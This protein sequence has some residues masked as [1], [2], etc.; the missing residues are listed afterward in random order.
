MKT[1]AYALVI[2]AALHGVAVVLAGFAASSLTLIVPAILYL[3]LAAGLSRH[4]M[5]VAWLS[6]IVMLGGIA[7]ALA[8]VVGASPVPTWVFGSILAA[9][10]VAAVLL[11]GAI[12][13][14]R[15]TD[16]R[17]I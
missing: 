7:A 16:Q 13:S 15:R 10:A 9:N 12:W 17:A 14:G 5:W 8:S 4:M 1:A 3:A 11:F 2:S 6:F